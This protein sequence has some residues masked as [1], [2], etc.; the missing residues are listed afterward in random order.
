M[1]DEKT[2]M[3]NTLSGRYGNLAWEMLEDMKGKRFSHK[4]A[5]KYP[6]YIMDNWHNEEVCRTV[7]IWTSNSE[8]CVTHLNEDLKNKFFDKYTDYI[9]GDYT[10]LVKTSWSKPS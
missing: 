8:F 1:I 6:T 2:H 10:K 9:R 7:R 4:K 5:S 3:W